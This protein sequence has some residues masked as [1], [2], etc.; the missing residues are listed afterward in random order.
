MVAA[1]LGGVAQVVLSRGD[2]PGVAA[3]QH[4]RPAQHDL[5][6]VGVAVGV[7]PTVTTLPTTTCFAPSVEADAEHVAVVGGDDD[8]AAGVGRG[9]QQALERAQVLDRVLACEHTAAEGV[10]DGVDHGADE[11]GARRAERVE[12]S[13]R[14]ADADATAEVLVVVEQQRR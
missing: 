3:A 10:V 9:A 11:S 6:G 7:A 2:D 5:V 13:T 4:T 1:V 8:D 12:H 14:E